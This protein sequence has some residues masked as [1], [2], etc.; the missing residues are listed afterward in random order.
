[1]TAPEI[2]VV[3]IETAPAEVYTWGLFNQN[4]SISQ[5]IKPGSILCFSAMKIGDKKPESLSVWDVGYEAMIN[6]L[7]QIYSS[8]T[9]I[10]GYNHI[11][12]DNRWIR[13]AFAELKLPPP[14]PW[15]DID[16]Y[17]VV[18]RHFQF[19]SNKLDYVCQA[20]G[21]GKKLKHSGQELWNECLRPTTEK[22]GEQA[23]KTMLK[24]CAQDVK[25]TR[26]L[27]ERVRGWIPNINLPI[28]EEGPG[29][30][31][32]N[33][34]SKNVQYRGYAYTTTRTYRRFQ[35]QQSGCGKWG[36]ETKSIDTT[37]TTGI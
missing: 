25:I 36:R 19:P 18:R 21:V 30:R 10:V 11:N 2:W 24:Y 16:L 9:H 28:H 27:F 3:D 29:P 32:T 1:M 8:A 34:S 35:C 37:G 31:C 22:S 23:R 33:C 4:H 26:D 5:I 15:K 12:Y 6:R 14:A 7:Y 20:L 13:A 17:R